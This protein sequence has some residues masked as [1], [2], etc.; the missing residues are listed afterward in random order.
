MEELCQHI[1]GG[2]VIAA[3][4]SGL[5]QL[6]AGLVDVHVDTAGRTLGD[7]DQNLAR[8]DGLAHT[9]D[10]S[11]TRRGISGTESFQN[12]SPGFLSEK[13]V[14]HNPGSDS[15]VDLQDGNPRV[16]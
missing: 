16:K 10:E 5:L 9:I 12:D 14:S 6:L 7:V 8:S 3:K 2:T 11:A 4:D 1:L 13:D 15:G